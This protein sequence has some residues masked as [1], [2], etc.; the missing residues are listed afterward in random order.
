MKKTISLLMAALLILSLTLTAV[1]CGRQSDK[2]AAPGK[3]AS[4]GE[5]AEPVEPDEPVEPVEPDE[6]GAEAAGPLPLMWRVTDK[7]GHTLYLFGTIHVGD[8]RNDAVMARVAPVLDGCDALAVEFDAVAY[9]GDMQQMMKDMEQYVLTDGSTVSDY[10]PEDLYQRSYELLKQAGLMPGVFTHYNLAW[11]SQ[12]VES[13]ILTVY[14]ELDS[15]KAMDSLLIHRAYDRDIPV[16]DVESSAF[17][18]ALLNSFDNELYLLM[19]EDALENAETY[20]TDL[21]R[22]YELWLSGDRDAFWTYLASE[23]DEDDGNYTEQQLAM[24]E[25]Y[26]R[27]LLDERNLGMRDRAMEYL[28]S[29][30]TVFFA[31]GA[32]HMANEAGLVQLLTDAGYTVEE[33]AY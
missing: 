11:W 29:G 9:A 24:I 26:N 15:G 10:M 5:P 32:A 23:N 25:D 27:A 14:T 12:L 28:A 13:A 7:D 19:I 33:I 20:N 8:E 4:A 31:V 6:P 18:M 2:P 16:L 22:L 1:S 21:N 17:Q 30:R 3:P